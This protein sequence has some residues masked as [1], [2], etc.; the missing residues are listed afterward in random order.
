MIG[1]TTA[2]FSTSIPITISD[3]ENDIVS[4]TLCAEYGTISAT[5]L[6]EKIQNGS[7][8][9]FT[10]TASNVQMDLNNLRI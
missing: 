5:D 7:L 1:L 9:T 8:I 6:N 3:P 2:P 10:G 4:V